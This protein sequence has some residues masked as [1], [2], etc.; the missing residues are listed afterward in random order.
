MTSQPR[1]RLLELF[2]IGDPLGRR[3]LWDPIE[4]VMPPAVYRQIV[5]RPRIEQAYR[6]A[7]PE[8]S[9]EQIEALVDE[10]LYT[11]AGVEIPA[12]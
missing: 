4:A 8:M 3:I 12:N 5:V 7:R 11:E 9:E 6:S 2:P 10:F 1:N